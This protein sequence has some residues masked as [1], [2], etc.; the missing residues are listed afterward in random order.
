[1]DVVVAGAG[2]TGAAV[3]FVAAF[4]VAVDAA[5]VDAVYA[6]PVDDGAAAAAEPELTAVLALST[7]S[8]WVNH[9][10]SH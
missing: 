1:M 2:A 7:L 10:F 5:A 8:S 9:C 3:A 4:A 6:A